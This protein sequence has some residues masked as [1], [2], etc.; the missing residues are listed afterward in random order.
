MTAAKTEYKWRFIILILAFIAAILISVIAGRYAVSIGDFFK[1]LWSRLPFAGDVSA[2]WTNSA[3]TILLEVRLP[4]IACAVLIGAAL[5][6]AGV[7]YQG[8]FRN[9]MVSPDLLGAS[10]GAGFGAALAI[11]LGAGYFL[12][13]ASAFVFG[14]GAVLL[15][16]CVSRFSKTNET[17]ALILGGI[18]ISSLFSAGT[19]FIKLVAD[20]QEQ[21]PAITYWL[22]GSLSSIQPKDLGFVVIPIAI[23]MIPLFLLRWRLNLLTVEE[24][25]SKSVG[26]NVT[27]LRLIVIICA[28]LIT[29]ASVSV[30]GMIGWVGLVIPHFCRMIFGYD[31]RRLVP[32]TVLFGATFLLIV[33]DIA[34]LVT[35]RELPI[36]ILTSF[37]G[38]PLFIYLLVT[39]GG[40]RR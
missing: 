24:E 5:S 21:L 10:T 19:S 38:A 30:S 9:P 29:A 23:G 25:T 1:I 37:V 12:I 33:D 17:L 40:N 22:M 6:L 14:I 20:T 11:L 39:G 34:R 8:M 31:Y 36:G 2:T 15:A 7:C 18:V 26:I 4:R 35:T 27:L 13:S 32:A 28:T 3:E 16:Y